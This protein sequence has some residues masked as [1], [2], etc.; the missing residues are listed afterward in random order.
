[1][2]LSE[3]V[4]DHNQLT[5]IIY[6]P[7]DDPMRIPKLIQ[8]LVELIEDYLPEDQRTFIGPVAVCYLIHKLNELKWHP[9]L[10]RWLI[11]SVEKHLPEQTG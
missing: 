7:A 6:L 2:V 5:E 3:D 8:H 9:S 1:M 4:A 11:D 10:Q